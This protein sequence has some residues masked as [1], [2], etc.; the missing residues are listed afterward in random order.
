VKND[1]EEKDKRREGRE[2]HF[3]A[4]VPFVVQL[5]VKCPKLPPNQRLLEA[6]LYSLRVFTAIYCM[7]VYA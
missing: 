7:P 3:L 4:I 2:A 1:N 5:I 6:S